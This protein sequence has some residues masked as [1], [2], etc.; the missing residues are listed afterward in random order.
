MIE[1]T[2]KV[3]DKLLRSTNS[4]TAL[5]EEILL[6]AALQL[7]RAEKITSK[8][9]AKLANLS[10]A[11]F[12]K[13]AQETTDLPPVETNISLGPMTSIEGSRYL[14]R[15]LW[16]LSEGEKQKLTPMTAAEIAKYVSTNSNFEVQQTNTA[17]FFRESR[18]TG[19]FEEY[20]TAYDDE[21]RLRYKLTPK[22]RALVKKSLNAT[23]PQTR[24]SN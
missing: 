11:K 1:L 16:A 3:P 18:K 5:S 21:P 4:T 7:Y 2:I 13:E 19:R 14:A 23:Q 10:H 6:S 22:G 17:R 15:A 12:L 20:W 9:A 8:R 24:S